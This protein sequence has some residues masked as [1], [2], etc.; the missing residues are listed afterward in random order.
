VPLIPL[1]DAA[2]TQKVSYQVRLRSMWLVTNMQ[3]PSLLHVVPGSRMLCEGA[4]ILAQMHNSRPYLHW[5]PFIT[6][7]GRGKSLYLLPGATSA[8]AAAAAP[9]ASV[10]AA[11]LQP[12]L[13]VLLC[14]LISAP[15][16]VPQP[17]TIQQQEAAAAD[18]KQQGAAL[19]PYAAA[20]RST[21]THPCSV[22][23]PTFHCDN[24]VF[25]P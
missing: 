1:K 20:H 8:A 19:H 16:T 6:A 3:C 9:V 10:A 23:K 7:S 13:P 24:L 4:R 5:I 2:I 14:R 18:S 12:L 17:S 22:S 11:I 15:E 25:S 21:S